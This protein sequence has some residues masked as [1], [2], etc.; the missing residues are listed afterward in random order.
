MKAETAY[1][2][3]HDKADILTAMRSVLAR[4]DSKLPPPVAAFEG[5]VG[6]EP[7]PVAD[8]ARSILDRLIQFGVARFKAPEPVRGGGHLPGYPGAVQG[9]PH[10]SGGD[11]GGLHRHQHGGRGAGGDRRD[12]RKLLK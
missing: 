8:K 12:C 4:T 6:R 11:G 2:Y 9:Q 10:P 3:V 5:I 7:Y 1:Q